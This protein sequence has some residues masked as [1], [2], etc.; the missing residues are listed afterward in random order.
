MGPGDSALKKD[1]K[2]YIIKCIDETLKY[3]Q[4]SLKGTN[5]KFKVGYTPKSFQNYINEEKGY[6][7]NIDYIKEVFDEVYNSIKYEPSE[8]KRKLLL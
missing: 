5:S 1:I 3:K 4:T 2:E 8:E 6:T 7:V